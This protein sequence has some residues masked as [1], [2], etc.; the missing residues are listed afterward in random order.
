ME[1]AV[2]HPVEVGVVFR[3][4]AAQPV[5]FKWGRR[6]YDVREVTYAWRERTG[7]SPAHHYAVTDGANVFELRLDAETLRWSLGR[8]WSR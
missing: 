7:R 8:V 4:A 1:T 3:E 2:E 5:W 6:T